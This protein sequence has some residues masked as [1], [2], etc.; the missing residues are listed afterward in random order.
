MGEAEFKHKS[1]AERYNVEG[2]TRHTCYIPYTLFWAFL[3]IIVTCC[4]C[5]FI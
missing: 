3:F 2:N 4:F 1:Y 5:T